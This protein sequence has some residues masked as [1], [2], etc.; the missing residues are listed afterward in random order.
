MS[1]GAT[2]LYWFL[3]GMP[4]YLILAL[5]IARIMDLAHARGTDDGEA[6]RHSGLRDSPVARGDV[7]G[8]RTAWRDAVRPSNGQP[9]GKYVDVSAD[10]PLTAKGEKG[11]QR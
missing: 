10:K 1:D 6:D 9:A 4:G 2:L 8:S 3:V 5:C 11:P 7:V